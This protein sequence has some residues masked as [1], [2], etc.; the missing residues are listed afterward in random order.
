VRPCERGSYKKR[1]RQRRSDE[2]RK[3]REGE[4][5]KEAGD[6]GKAL[7]GRRVERRLRGED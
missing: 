4:E 1:H 6:A 7:E 3:A 2:A 5:A